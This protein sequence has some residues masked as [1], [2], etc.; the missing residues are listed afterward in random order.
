MS[1]C[2]PCSAYLHVGGGGDQHSQRVLADRPEGA[3]LPG[4]GVAAQTRFREGGDSLLGFGRQSRVGPISQR[5]CERRGGSLIRVIGGRAFGRPWVRV[6]LRRD[7]V[8]DFPPRL[9]RGGVEPVGEVP[10]GHV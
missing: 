5:A 8:G 4:G 1:S 6:V 2:A 9:R 7:V 10:A 3:L